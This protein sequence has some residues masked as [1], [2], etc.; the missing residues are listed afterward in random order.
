L[1]EVAVEVRTVHLRSTE[2]EWM[3]PLQHPEQPDVMD[4]PR[5][6]QLAQVENQED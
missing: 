3:L 5:V 6:E 1:P 4:L 2:T